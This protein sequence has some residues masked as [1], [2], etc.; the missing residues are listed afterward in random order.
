MAIDY[1]KVIQI[2]LIQF[3]AQVERNSKFSRR[4]IDVKSNLILFLLKC[5]SCFMKIFLA[6]IEYLNAH[7]LTQV[8]L[9]GANYM[10]S[11]KTSYLLLNSE[12]RRFSVHST[13]SGIIFGLSRFIIPCM[14]VLLAYQNYDSKNELIEHFG[15]GNLILGKKG[16]INILVCLVK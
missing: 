16:N 1:V 4:V 2:D 8:A 10:D 13:I 14:S 15:M 12:K 9:S 3:Q 5:I 7:T 6:T 11:S